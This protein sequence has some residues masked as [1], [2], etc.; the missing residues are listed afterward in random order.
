M[1]GISM[2][3]V[4]LR[5]EGGFEIFYTERGGRDG[6]RHYASEDEACVEFLEIMLQYGEGVRSYCLGATMNREKADELMKALQKISASI[7]FDI[8]RRG[9]GTYPWY[10][11]SVDW[12]KSE[13]AKAIADPSDLEWKMD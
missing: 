7:R 8:V 5:I 11:L 6:I 12:K 2:C 9:D 10:A 4:L 1:S 3:P 13:R